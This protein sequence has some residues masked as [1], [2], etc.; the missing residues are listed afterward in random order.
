MDGPA[1]SARVL[2]DWARHHQV[3]LPGLEVRP[4]TLEEIYLR[5]TGETS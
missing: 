1:V 4:P 3:G 2:L 5:L